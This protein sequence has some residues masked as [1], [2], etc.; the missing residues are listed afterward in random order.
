MG[1]TNGDVDKLH[2]LTGGH[3]RMAFVVA[4]EIQALVKRYGI[5]RIGFFALMFAD[6]V[7]DLREAAKAVSDIIRAPLPTQS[8]T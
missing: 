2:I 1:C 3:K 6:H 8:L 7:T 4:T 5:E